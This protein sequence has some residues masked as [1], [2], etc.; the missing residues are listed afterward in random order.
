MTITPPPATMPTAA[1]APDTT[2]AGLTRRFVAAM[3]AGDLDALDDLLD[4]GIVDHHLPPGIPAG[5]AGVKLWCSMLRDAL[6]LHVVIEDLVGDGDRVAV[7]GRIT[8]T[9]V[10]EFAGMP[11][12]GRRFDAS[13]LSIERAEAGRLVERWEIPDNATVMAQLNDED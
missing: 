2:A 5:I 4:P 7:R 13:F 11:A 6:D 8:G 1:P 9:H 10:G 3:N 12:T